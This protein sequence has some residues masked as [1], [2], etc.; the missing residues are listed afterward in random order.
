[1][2][3]LIGWD[4]DVADGLFAFGGSGCYFY[5]AHN[6]LSAVAWETNRAMDVKHLTSDVGVLG[7]DRD[8]SLPNLQEAALGFTAILVTQKKKD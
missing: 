2:A 7:R 6:M 1:M 5:G 4:P 8:R 3:D